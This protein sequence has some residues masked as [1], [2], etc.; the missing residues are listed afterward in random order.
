MRN[1]PSRTA[2]FTLVEVTIILAVL[3]ILATAITPMLL[4]Q[5]VDAKMETTRSETKALAEAI[6]GRPD[7]PGSFGFYG[8]LGRF[9]AGLEELVK[10]NPNTPYFSTLGFRGVGMGWKGPYINTGTSPTDAFVDGFGRQYR[11]TNIGQIR[12]AGSNGIFDDEDDV[13]YP[14]NPPMPYG[15][16]LVTV[17]RLD[18]GTLAYTLDPVGYTVRIYYAQNGT[19]VY[20]DDAAA[21]FVF[22]RVPQGV[23]AIA[24]LRGGTSLVAQDTIM[25]YPGGTPKLVEFV[26]R[27]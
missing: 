5:I 17:K 25:V 19:E 1:H 7:V 21:P 15:R 16:V 20:R 14:P 3:A 10:P 12:S 8:D 13:V 27:P 2:G 23:H 26:F 22:E 6:L 9:P 4:Q 24:L 18:A 11:L